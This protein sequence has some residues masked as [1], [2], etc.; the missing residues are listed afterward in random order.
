V[1][2][3]D[4]FEREGLL[5]M[6]QGL[7]LEPHYAECPDCAA[8]RRAHESLA[9]R[10]G[11]LGQDEL[12]ASGWEQRVREALQARPAPRR[13]WPR[14]WLTVPVTALAA[15]VL[16]VAGTHLLRPT[17]AA[18]AV[19]TRGDPRTTLR[20][21]PVSPG[22]V[23]TLEA[24]TGGASYAE[25]RVYRDDTEIVL[26]CSTT[27]PCRRSGR[28]LSAELTLPAIG[29]YQPVLLLAARALP[30]PRG[31]LDRDGADVL[32]AGGQFILGREVEAR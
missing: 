20:G 11:A 22:D 19:S 6:E 16:A 26:R 17:A 32:D 14:P 27:L 9:R 7:P 5:R 24:Q 30:V 28:R 29:L 15:V 1:S 2:G 23:L 25:L 13:F 31:S 10:I 4:R 3:C 21:G 18:L 12:P 8:A